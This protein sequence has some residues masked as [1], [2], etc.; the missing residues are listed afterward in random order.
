MDSATHRT[1]GYGFVKFV[2]EGPALAAIAAMNGFEIFGK[3]LKV[4]IA[5]EATPP[6]GKPKVPP[7]YGVNKPPIFS[8]PPPPPQPALP[9][10]APPSAPLGLGL[11]YGTPAALHTMPQLSGLLQQVQHVP[12]HQHQHHHH[13]QS[14]P[15]FIIPASQ[16]N[17][18]IDENMLFLPQMPNNQQ[19][20]YIVH[21]QH[22]SPVVS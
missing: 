7:P 16:P 22:V 3:R 12:Q 18:H 19:M 9:Y 14:Q 20:F 21:Q 15:T 13:H 8:A 5:R 11:P 6:G 4:S 17:S 2:D 1:K 10:H